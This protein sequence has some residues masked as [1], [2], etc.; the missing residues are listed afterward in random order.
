M[1]PKQQCKNST[2]VSVQ[3]LGDRLNSLS[4]ITVFPKQQNKGQ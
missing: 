4:K 1:T 3:G 2:L